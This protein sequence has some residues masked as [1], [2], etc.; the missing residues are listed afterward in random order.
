MSTNPNSLY[1]F[2]LYFCGSLI[3]VFVN[4]LISLR[5]LFLVLSCP[6]KQN[7]FFILP[8]LYQTC[9]HFFLHSQTHTH[10]YMLNVLQW[11]TMYLCGNCTINKKQQTIKNRHTIENLFVFK[12]WFMYGSMFSLSLSLSPLSL[13]LC[14][15][16]SLI[17]SDCKTHF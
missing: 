15:F 10:Q 13:I 16:F 4:N 6:A 9:L 7:N 2:N 1:L 17:S 3:F 5:F 14:F 11:N 12:T 8:I